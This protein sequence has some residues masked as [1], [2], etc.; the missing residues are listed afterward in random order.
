MNGS[1]NGSNGSNTNGNWPGRANT[2]GA[3]PG[4]GE[5]FDLFPERTTLAEDILLLHTRP[6]SGRLPAVGGG[7]SLALAGALVM[8]LLRAGELALDK[9]G[10]HLTLTGGGPTSWSPRPRAAAPD[11]LLA[12][13]A[14]ALGQDRR[15]AQRGGSPTAFVRRLDNRF[16][17]E[18]VRAALLD[19]GLL[20]AEPR[21]FLGLIPYTVFAATAPAPIAARATVLAAVAHDPQPPHRALQLFALAKLLR[22]DA[23]HL[24]RAAN[25][26]P[27]RHQRTRL[28]RLAESDPVLHTTLRLIRSRQASDNATTAAS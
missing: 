1:S 5:G 18:A 23:R 25:P 26:R 24:P 6:A 17:I 12:W 20:R 27:D 21:K 7:A 13:A 4:P 19:R 10:R 2:S 8:D 22:L 11:P 16:T 28:N 9:P 15:L 14:N 3:A